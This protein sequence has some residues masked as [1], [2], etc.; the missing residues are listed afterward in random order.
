MKFKPVLTEKS[1]NDAKVG[2]YT[3]WVGANVTK[4]Q[5]KKILEDA[6]KVDVKTVR[7]PKKAGEVRRTYTRGIRVTKDARKVVVTLGDK[8]T[9]DLFETEKKTEKKKKK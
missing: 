5:A 9:I 3:F 8:Q 7:T 2:K 4:F 6:F 1:L